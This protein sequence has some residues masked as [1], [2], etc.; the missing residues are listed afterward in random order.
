M[1]SLSRLFSWQA[2]ICTDFLSCLLQCH[3]KTNRKIQNIFKCSNFMEIIYLCLVLFLSGL[4]YLLVTRDSINNAKTIPSLD[5]LKLFIANNLIYAVLIFAG[6]G[7]LFIVFGS[8]K[9]CVL[10]FVIQA[11]PSLGIFFYY[12]YVKNKGK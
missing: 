5:Y 7:V 8:K 9:L 2:R 4:I 6:Y 11:I 12:V 3:R 1:N 10:L